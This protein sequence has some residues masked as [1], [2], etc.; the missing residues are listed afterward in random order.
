MVQMKE[1]EEGWCDD[2]ETGRFGPCQW[3]PQAWDAA[4][5]GSFGCD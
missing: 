3:M 2:G 5:G 4:S 1:A